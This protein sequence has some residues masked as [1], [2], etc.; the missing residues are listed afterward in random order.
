MKHHVINII[1]CDKI[2]Y[3]YHRKFRCLSRRKHLLNLDWK[4]RE[5]LNALQA[6][7][8]AIGENR[9]SKNKFK[10]IFSFLNFSL[11]FSK[12]N[13]G[14]VVLFYLSKNDFTFNIILGIAQVKNTAQP[15]VFSLRKSIFFCKNKFEHTYTH[16]T[17]F[18][19][20]VWRVFGCIES[21]KKNW[22][23]HIDKGLD[24]A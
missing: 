4:W 24:E 7:D 20:L 21:L 6:T 11:H 5:N 22:L 9:E 2:I 19:S 12:E 23:K 10:D 13:L 1:N 3:V 17:E 18:W 8:K 14:L 15:N 16:F